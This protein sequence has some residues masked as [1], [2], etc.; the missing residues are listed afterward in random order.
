MIGPNGTVSIVASAEG[1]EARAGSAETA[2][3]DVDSHGKTGALRLHHA[4]LR[5]GGTFASSDEIIRTD[6]EPSHQ[7]LCDR[8]QQFFLEAIRNDL[9]MT[10]QMNDA[11][12]TL[13]ILLAADRSVRT[14]EVVRL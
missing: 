12:N 11:V 14:G 6:D 2:S 4:R 13:R 3:S 1:N 10:D 9:D 8:E 7:Q 5:P